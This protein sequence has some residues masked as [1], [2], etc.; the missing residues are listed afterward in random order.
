MQ[1]LLDDKKHSA[2]YKNNFLDTISTIYTETTWKCDK[3]IP[4]PHF[5]R[6]SRH[7]KKSDSFTEEEL[8]RFLSPDSFTN[9][10]YCLFFNL[11][12]CCGLRLGE[13]CG[14]KVKQFVWNEHALIVD[15]FCKLDGTRTNYNK[16]GS[17]ENK[18][19]R[20][21]PVP[22][23]LE[24]IILEYKDRNKIDEN[25]FLF[26]RPDK[27]P[28]TEYRMIKVFNK[29]LERAG[30]EKNER[31]LTPHS[32]RY[33]FITY[34]R[35]VLDGDEV[36]KIAGHTDIVMTDYYTR[37]LLQNEIRGIKESFSAVDNVFN[38]VCLKYKK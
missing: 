36:R 37:F 25:S 12:V 7:S 19:I 35:S 1:F 9:Y 8:K 30:I 27:T 20:V 28:F 34:M 13:T 15:G 29:A 23:V 5:Q 4:C 11:M 3:Q 32:L 21:V 38:P 14:I 2:S 33:T 18:K 17:D 6:F 16:K 24:R 31:K 22:K 10:A 26:C